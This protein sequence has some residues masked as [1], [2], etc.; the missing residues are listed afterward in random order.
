MS[1]NF[2]A[3][4]WDEIKKN[5]GLWWDGKLD[6]PLIPV[7]LEGADPKRPQPSAPLLTQETCHDLTVPA[8]DIVDR[9][10]YELS[11]NKYMADAF[12]SLNLTSFGPGVAAAFMCRPYSV[13]HMYAM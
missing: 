11:K 7:I 3:N 8:R 12:P 9:I 4:Q 6:R 5:Y 1:I 10:D 13:L 2:T